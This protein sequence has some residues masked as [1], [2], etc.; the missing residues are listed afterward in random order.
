MRS[1]LWLLLVA[2][3]CGKVSGDS[4]DG[5]ELPEIDAGAGT[6]QLQV[7]STE[8]NGVRGSTYRLGFKVDRSG[9]F[10]GEVT[11]DMPSPPTGFSATFE[12]NPVPPGVEDV[13][14]VIVTPRVLGQNP[15]TL[16]LH[17]SASV[18]EDSV[19]LTVTLGSID[20][21]GKV[22]NPFGGLAQD[23]T[24]VT[25]PGVGSTA[26]AADGTF[27]IAGSHAPYEIVVGVQGLKGRTM[28]VG[29]TRTDPVLRDYTWFG[30][31][32][33]VAVK[34]APVDITLAN[35]VSADCN[36]TKTARWMDLAGDQTTIFSPSLAFGSSCK[37][38]GDFIWDI[39]L[40][41][42]INPTLHALVGRPAGPFTYATTTLA[43]VD[44]AS[45]AQV[46]TMNLASVPTGQL[47][48]T[49]GIPPGA[50]ALTLLVLLQKGDEEVA[51]IF[52]T[53]NTGEAVFPKP[54]PVIAGFKYKV[55]MNVTVTSGSRGFMSRDGLDV[56]V[57][58]DLTLPPPT[59]A[60]TPADDATG[61]DEATVFSWT[62]HTP[63]T[64]Y[65]L[66]ARHVADCASDPGACQGSS[67]TVITNATSTTLP[68]GT[69]TGEYKW[70]VEGTSVSTVDDEATNTSLL[71]VRPNST[72]TT[73]SSHQLQFT[74]D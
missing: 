19:D 53:V 55:S 23:N 33:P 40:P 35:V 48:G 67:F 1:S 71:S 63:Q 38:T 11:L 43:L 10:D 50:T 36:S 31:G 7:Q 45:A 70:Y 17:S 26:A 15:N 13:T 46:K 32:P 9:G 28:Y 51:E 47:M 25:I 6:Y 34:S 73:S 66:T 16:Q 18:G 4:P 49:V 37:M 57:P 56:D 68:L 24:T 20:V 3:A 8:L 69:A 27:T 44:G 22:T 42:S 60:L 5:G 29:L 21:A 2:A 65:R 54:V 61:V 62:A 72:F 52:R 74:I 39:S 58:N 41:N 64:T 14:A 12:P 59:E 30:L